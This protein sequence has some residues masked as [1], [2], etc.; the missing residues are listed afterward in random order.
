[1]A[2]A[3]ERLKHGK[4]LCGKVFRTFVETFNW[5]TSFCL[6]LKGDGDFPGSN[7]NITLDRSNPDFPVIRFKELEEEE[8]ET[9]QTPCWSFS[10]TGGWTNCILQLGYNHFMIS[11]D[12]SEQTHARITGHSS[13]ISGTDRDDDGEYVVEVNLR[14]ETATIMLKG[15]ASFTY[16]IDHENEVVY[17]D[18]GKVEDGV[19]TSGIPHHP[20]IYKYV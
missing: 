1:M 3:R 5:H 12:V 8:E 11:S 19:Q 2:D 20:V 14:N 9:K 16:P 15:E 6:N 13:L 7:G 4:A 17:I 10:D 18:I